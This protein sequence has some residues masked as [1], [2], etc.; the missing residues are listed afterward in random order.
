MPLFIDIF[1]KHT[2]YKEWDQRSRIVKKKKVDNAI[3]TR[4]LL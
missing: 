1:S 2:K 4:A 3:Y